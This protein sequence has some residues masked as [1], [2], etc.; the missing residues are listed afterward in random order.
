VSERPIVAR[1][2]EVIAERKTCPREERSYVA[3]LTRGGPAK[4]VGKIAEEACEVV[5]E[6]MG[7]GWS[8]TFLPSYATPS[9]ESGQFRY[10]LSS[11][12]DVRVL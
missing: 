6:G 11:R 1:L 10:H 12:Q 3:S 9:H 4:I 7:P 2:L 8:R 5:V